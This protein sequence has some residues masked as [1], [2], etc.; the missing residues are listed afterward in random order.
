VAERVASAITARV[1]GARIIDDAGDDVDLPNQ[2]VIVRLF[3]DRCTVSVDS[4]GALL[5][6]RGY[7]QAVAKAPI[8]ETLAAATLIASGWRGDAPLLDP[9]CG[10]G[11]I[12]IEGAMIARRM[13]PG[14]RRQFAF[15]QWPDFDSGTWRAVL[16]EA[17]SAIQPASPVSIQ[18][19][20][21]DAGAVDA[22][23]ANADRAGV[24][25]DIGFSAR[26]ISAIEPAAEAGWLVANPPYGVRVGDTDRLQNLYAQL[27]NVIRVKCPNWHVALVSAEQ[28]LERQ[29]GLRLLPVLRTFNGGIRV[30]VIAGVVTPPA[31]EARLRDRR[32]RPL[33]PAPIDQ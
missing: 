28:K 25:S 26:S 4:S 6:R 7:R 9:M 19:S 27:G 21:R 14:L 23:M 20:D 22:A 31:A 5:H 12:P 16:D 17:E 24:G 30:R 3:H 33:K 32:R 8:R 18:G 1:R 2:L 15:E 13:A 29:L 10:S 11:T